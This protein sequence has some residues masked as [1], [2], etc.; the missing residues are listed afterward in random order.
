MRVSIDI[1]TPPRLVDRV[2]VYDDLELDPFVT[3][4]GKAGCEDADEFAAACLAGLVSAEEE[5]HALAA[6]TQLDAALS[7]REPPFDATGDDRLAEAVV[8][9]LAP[10][11]DL[12]H[13]PVFSRTA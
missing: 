6:A 9:G 13:L 2:W 5:R 4:Q 10:L 3:Q 8:L 7:G 11:T 1:S 12:S